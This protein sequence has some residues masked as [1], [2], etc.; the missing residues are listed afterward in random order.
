MPVM[1]AVMINDTTNGKPITEEK[2]KPTYAPN[3][4]TAPWA[5]LLK[6]KMLNTRQ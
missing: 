2:R 5:K 3:M 1:I 4:I 6:F